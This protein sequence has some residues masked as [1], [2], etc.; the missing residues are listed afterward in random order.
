L[1]CSFSKGFSGFSGIS[2]KLV[3]PPYVAIMNMYPIVG[4]GISYIYIQKKTKI[5]HILIRMIMRL[6]IVSQYVVRMNL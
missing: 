5:M 3:I 2:E 1:V 4:S 6:E